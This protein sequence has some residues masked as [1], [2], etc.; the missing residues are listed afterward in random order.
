GHILS[1]QFQ[2]LGLRIKSTLD[3]ERGTISPSRNMSVETIICP[4]SLSAIISGWLSQSAATAIV[5]GLFVAIKAVFPCV[6]I[7][8]THVLSILTVTVYASHTATKLFS[9]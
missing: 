8:M 7:H 4:A 2:A 5:S 1:F 3:I 9:R 6:T